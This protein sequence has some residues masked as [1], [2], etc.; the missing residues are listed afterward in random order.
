M[1]ET[2]LNGEKLAMLRLNER[3]YSRGQQSRIVDQLPAVILQQIT[4]ETGP[5]Q[6]DA[7][8]DQGLADA[9]GTS[10]ATDAMQDGE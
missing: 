9:K 10:D 6:T 4:P 2:R 8:I 1:E 5:L 7:L 3:G